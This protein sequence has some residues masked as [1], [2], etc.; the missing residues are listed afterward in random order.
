M[1]VS[2]RGVQ[3]EL[4]PKLQEKL[5]A[6][7]SKIAKL[8]EKRGEKEA[9]VVVTTERHLHHAEITMQF[10]DH[11]LIGLGS[12]AD[13]F[14]ALHSALE[15][16]EKQAVKASTKWREKNRRSE[17][18]PAGSEEEQQSAPAAPESRSFGR[19]NKEVRVFPVN[20]HEQRKPMTLEEAV[21]EMETD[22]DYMVYRD[23]DKD[24]VS[25]LVRRRDGHFD[26]IE[27]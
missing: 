6:K 5:D 14:A 26:L 18:S 16:L 3:R 27:S 12:D 17:K 21:L 23:A 24:C 20:H 11:Q 1:N 13:L 25:V 4:P 2:Y 9:H 22:R 19:G 15:K 8:L 7:F 10:Y